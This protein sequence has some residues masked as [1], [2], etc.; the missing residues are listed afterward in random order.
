MR[1]TSLVQPVVCSEF[2]LHIATDQVGVVTDVCTV[3]IETYK[4]IRLAE[5][6]FLTAPTGE[7]RP[8]TDAEIKKRHRVA[9]SIRPLALPALPAAPSRICYHLHGG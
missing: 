3:G 9:A 7:F 6:E 4:T 5:G 8:A 2:V 1:R